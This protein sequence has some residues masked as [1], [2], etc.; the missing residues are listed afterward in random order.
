ME[1]IRNQFAAMPEVSSVSLSYEIPNG[2]NG[3]QPS[4]YNAGA[5]ST[6]A[7]PMQAM[8]TDENY[9]STYQIP[10]ADGAFFDSRGLDS[11]KVILSEKAVK[12]LGYKTVSAATGRQ[13]RIPGDP[14]VYTIKGVVNDFHFGSMQDGIQPV[15]FFNVGSA[16]T[17]RF[18]SFKLRP[19]NITTSI[20]AIQKKWSQLMP[21]SSFEYSFMDDA[22][23]KLYALE[24]QLKKAAYAATVLS[25]VIV[26]LGVLGLVSLSIHKRIKEVGIRKVLG[27]SAGS[28][29]LLFIKEFAWII[30]VAAIIASPVAYVIMNN[31]LN[32]YASH[33]SITVQP[34]ALSIFALAFITLILI[35]IQ[36]IKTAF[37]NPVK[38]LR[39]E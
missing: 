7:V 30:F 31:W 34:F 2:M 1:T 16:I 38:S 4:L 21:G 27:A 10:L 22:L 26:L 23:K 37:T 13:V 28:V 39:T 6:A 32:N 14:T 36:T 20:E 8:V 3:G 15:V 24:I 12:A 19:G 9:L 18:L 29:V 35:T 11:G 25:L 33:I 17:Y 5:D